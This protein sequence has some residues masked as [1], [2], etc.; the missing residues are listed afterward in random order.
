MLIVVDYLVLLHSAHNYPSLVCNIS[1]VSLWCR[2]TEGGSDISVV[3]KQAS[4][5]YSPSFSDS[6]LFAA[7][8]GVYIRHGP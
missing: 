6:L 7:C 4:Y 1:V 3:A 2:V 8:M 5:F